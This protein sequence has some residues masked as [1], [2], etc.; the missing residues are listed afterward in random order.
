V[1]PPNDTI[2]E[3]TKT[4]DIITTVYNKLIAPPGEV[5]Y[6]F[7]DLFDVVDIEMM[8]AAIKI[9]ENCLFFMT[10]PFVASCSTLIIMEYMFKFAHNIGQSYAMIPVR[11]GSELLMQSKFLR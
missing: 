3:I 9:D 10:A 2:T 8:Y 11:T 6:L 1:E 5:T 7:K 4:T